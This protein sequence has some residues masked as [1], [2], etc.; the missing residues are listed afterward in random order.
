M[1]KKTLRITKAT[2]NEAVVQV[3]A[4]QKQLLENCEL[5]ARLIK[6]HEIY[7]SDFIKA[8]GRLEQ[9]TVNVFTNTELIED[10]EWKELIKSIILVERH[11]ECFNTKLKQWEPSHEKSY[12]ICS[13]VMTAE[14][15]HAII[16]NHW[17]I[18]NCNNHVRDVSLKEDENKTKSNAGILAR[19]RSLALN[20]LRLNK[21]ESIKR[22][23]Y[24]NSLSLDFLKKYKI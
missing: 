12:Y 22:T 3:K 14:E 6:A 5:T 21:V 18:E 15:M 23:L 2:N 13:T 10:T 11:R 20:I 1:S 19:M 16:K 17:L 9:R 4:N 24:K 7:Q 8:H